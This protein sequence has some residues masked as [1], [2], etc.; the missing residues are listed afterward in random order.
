VVKSCGDVGTVI[1]KASQKEIT[2][3]ELQLCDQ[4]GM[5][6]NVTLWGSDV[7]LLSST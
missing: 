6:V 1:G 2:K 7:S 4:S 5:V 3:R